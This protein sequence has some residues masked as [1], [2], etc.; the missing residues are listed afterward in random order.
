MEPF[1]TIKSKATPLDRSNVDTDQI[2][3]KQ[4]LKLVQRSGFGQFLFYNWRYDAEGKLK[5]FVLNDPKYANRQILLARE[6]FGSG[7]S[8]EHAAWAIQDYGFKSIIAISFADIFYN[9]CFKNGI[10]PITLGNDEIDMLFGNDDLEIEVDLIQQR[11]KAGS[12]VIRF[13]IDQ[14]RKTIL[15][16]GLDDIGITLQYKDKISEYE[17][18]LREKSLG[19][20]L[21][22][23]RLPD[24]Q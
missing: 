16:D 2:V 22:A 13:E 8:R 14:H 19:L 9:N 15:L 12:R 18:K 7:S 1:K 6:N 3:P 5:E 20:E 17:K 24:K 21:P 11:V 4:F 23:P 10:L